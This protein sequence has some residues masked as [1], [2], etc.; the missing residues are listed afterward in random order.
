MK[1]LNILEKTTDDRL[2]LLDLKATLD[3]LA[4]EYSETRELRPRYYKQLNRILSAFRATSKGVT[5]D[6]GSTIL[7]DT[8]LDGD[9]TSS[10]SLFSSGDFDFDNQ[11]DN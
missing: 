10:S 3:L 9:S 7:T 6:F 11:E 4:S 2:S 5:Y 1:Y 8:L